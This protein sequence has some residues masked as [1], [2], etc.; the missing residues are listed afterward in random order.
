MRK[1][2]FR[3]RFIRRTQEC[4]Q[5]RKFTFVIKKMQ[6]PWTVYSSFPQSLHLWWWKLLKHITS[7]PLNEPELHE[8]FCRTFI[9]LSL[10]CKFRSRRAKDLTRVS[11]TSLIS[12]IFM[13]YSSVAGRRSWCVHK[14]RDDE[15]QRN[16]CKK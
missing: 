2:W 9:T 16:T 12:T 14:D 10:M 4:E 5:K 3:L 15:Q 6:R 7:K 1:S 8:S 13:L 11:D